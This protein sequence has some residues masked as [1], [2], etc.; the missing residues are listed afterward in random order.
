[1]NRLYAFSLLLILPLGV[2]AQ[3]CSVDTL[4][5]FTWGNPNASES[6]VI[7]SDYSDVSDLEF[8]LRGNVN[9]VRGQE[10]F[11]SDNVNYLRQ[12]EI[13][14]TPNQ[15][16][17]GNLNVAI[18]GENTTYDFSKE[19]G[20]FNNVEYY[21]SKGD[22]I[23]S[24]A[25]LWIDRTE[26]I[27]ELT[28]ATF[29]TCERA[30]PSWQ[31]KAKE[32]TLDHNTNT[33]EAW[34]A[35]FYIKDTPVFYLPYLSLPITDERKSGL[36]T[37]EFS[38][39]ETRGFD[40]TVPYYFNIAPNQD[41]TVFPRYMTKRGFMLGAEYRYLLPTL[42][43]S[44]TGTYLP[45]D[46]EDDT[47]RWSFRSEHIWTPTS[48]IHF[49]ARYQ[50]VSDKDYISDFEN[51]LDL[52]STSF[53]ES[54]LNGNFRLN[55]NYNVFAQIQEHQVAD[56]LYT[57]DDKPYSRLPRVIGNGQWF[58]DN[59]VDIETRTEVTNFDKKDSVSG[60]RFDNDITLSYM[61][62]NSFAYLNPKASYRFTS[63]DL[64]DLEYDDYGR[65]D[66]QVNRSIPILSVDS[67]LY[68]DRYFN[69]FGRDTIQTLEPRLFYLY[70][71]KKDQSDIPVFDT[72][73]VDVS[74][75]WLFMRN[76]F[77]GRDRIGDANQ[78]TTAIT[79][80]FIDEET[81]EENARF[82]LGQIQYFRDRE[83][84]LYD[85]LGESD[86]SSDFLAEAQVKL[87]SKLSTRALLHWNPNDN[88]TEKSV[89]GINY[90]LTRDKLLSLSYIYDK[91]SEYTDDT[92]HYEQ[93]D[94]TAVWRINDNW[95][96]FWRWNYSLDYNENIDI[97][98]GVEYR[99]CCWAV[100]LLGR[101]NRDDLTEELDSSI[102]LEF[103]LDG[104]GNVGSRTSDLL[105]EI[106]P[107]YEPL[108]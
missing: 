29:T 88:Q 75:D 89:F 17:Y 81:G 62:G 98:G 30:N 1:M 36:L 73:E 23:G 2:K 13:V 10:V 37:P 4:A 3:M 96:S 18:K 104:L 49:D 64:R 14:H 65:E 107:G 83:V 68:F 31:L 84:T 61:V 59:G 50:R 105:E 60:V 51:T 43:G 100:R 45:S 92:G 103:E 57:T 56:S 11:Q 67:G 22:A 66:D 53:L 108:R 27:E 58:F 87:S 55:N 9:I 34:H 46:I 71:P 47:K 19:Q 48:N 7:Q 38:I 28:N 85:S 26:N 72:S 8:N 95:R 94:F 42:H 15:M 90:Q 97:M 102:L 20:S 35:T 16:I 5:P 79:T 99:D 106:I 12:Q 70:V 78:L 39:S 101:Q 40:I 44:V 33:A 32:L 82:S 86:N 93:I 77:N 6:P 24:A 25:T 21:L 41:L 76:R 69:W 52:S 74:Y 54:H 80:R 91:G 63:Y